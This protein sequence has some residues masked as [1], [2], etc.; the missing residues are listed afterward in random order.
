MS[1]EDKYKG[2]TI[3]ELAQC[4]KDAK[5]MYDD[6]KS[7]SGE[8]YAEY[9]YLRLTL[10][11]AVMEEMGITSTNVKGVGRLT[12]TADL[13][14]S[15]P[16]AHKEAA[17]QWL[18]DNGHADIIAETVNSSTFKAFCKEQIKDG[19]ELPDDIFKID[20]FDRASLTKAPK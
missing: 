12:V 9:D 8:A 3:A 19:E 10:V 6:L 20:P 14:A 5:A 17:Y 13:R 4:L 11:P 7:Q 15:I 1:Y 2:K 16:A 18:R